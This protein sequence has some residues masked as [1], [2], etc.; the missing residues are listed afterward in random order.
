[1][2]KSSKAKILIVD[3]E[4]NILDVLKTVVHNEGY[5][6]K[7]TNLP[8]K[9]QEL[10]DKNDF[11]LVITDLK[12][13]PIDGLAVLRHAKRKDPNT[14]VLMMTAFATI[15][16][17]IE[18]L[19]AGAFDYIVKPF[20][21]DNVKLFIRR[22]LE[23]RATVIENINLKE[24]LK[25]KYSFENIIGESNAIRK[26][27]QRVQKVAAADATVLITGESGTGKEL[28]AKAIYANS[29]RH[30]MPFVSINCGAMVETLLES[31]LFGHV[32]GSFTDAVSDKKGLF[33]VADGGTIFLD[34]IGL[35]SK[36]FQMKLLRV[37]QEREIRR[38]GDTK[39]IKVDVRVIAA[40]NENLVEK[41]KN[42]TFREDLYYRLSVFPIHLPPLR[43]RTGDVALLIKHFLEIS[44][45]KLGK[46]FRPEKNFV[47]ILSKY[48]WP[49]NIRELENILE[50]SVLLADSN[51]L[52][53]E[54]L[55][56]TILSYAAA[57]NSAQNDDK[58][59]K[60]VTDEAQKSHILKVLE[61][62]DWNKKLT[63]KILG[64]D[65]AT[66]YR[67]MEKLNI[68]F[69]D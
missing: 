56:D 37:L 52:K 2:N 60:T 65:P 35:T 20:K 13:H 64:I 22:A 62:T 10:I 12:M 54:D 6:V 17:A 58:D 21:L 19:K 3:D 1:M 38:V 59:L 32:K 14:Q 23:H 40:T 43:E 27:I 42:L 57:N 69:K 49:G 26:V 48:N 8:D 29:N 36:S 18:A 28:F 31:E 44:S 50:R 15:E 16:T 67:K 66:L 33:Q 47:D 53:A 25:Q 7:A 24:V 63:A 41:V 9:A 55:P 30:N 34:E 61:E 51:I 4:I 11:D 39:D 45:A 5:S 46:I 68:N